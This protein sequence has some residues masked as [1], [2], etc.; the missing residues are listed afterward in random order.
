MTNA[1]HSPYIVGNWVTGD[2]FYGRA[3]LRTRLVEASDRGI[4]VLGTRRVGKTSLLRQVALDLAPL[5][6]YLDLMQAAGSEGGQTI[7][8]EA[9]LI[10]L[11]RRELGRLSRTSPDLEATRPLWDR[12]AAELCTWLEEAAWAWEERGATVTLLWDEAEMLLHLGAPALMGRRGWPR[13][14]TAGAIVARPSCS[15]S[16]PVRSA[17]LRMKRPTP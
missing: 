15:A 9:R 8:D 1:S 3:D 14:T 5:G 12:D 6:L 2:E 11:L 17:G 4:V 7:L 13:S 10:R 16:A